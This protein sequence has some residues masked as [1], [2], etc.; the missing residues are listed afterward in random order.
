MKTM[1]A[2]PCMDQVPVPFCQRL[3][4]LQKVGECTLAMKAGSLIYTSRNDLATRAI[5]GDFDYVFWLDSD[6]VFPPDGNMRPLKERLE[7]QG[8]AVTGTDAITT[9]LGHL[10]GI[11][12]IAKAGDSISAFMDK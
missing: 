1:I 10:D 3:A 2:V 8:V 4:R 6:M 9:S 12:N 5:Q 7:K 11:A